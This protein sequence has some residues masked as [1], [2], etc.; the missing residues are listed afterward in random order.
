MLFLLGLS[1]DSVLTGAGSPVTIMA[2]PVQDLGIAEI[3][4]LHREQMKELARTTLLHPLPFPTSHGDWG[5]IFLT[6]IWALCSPLKAPWRIAGPVV[7]TQAQI[8]LPAPQ[9]PHCHHQVHSSPLPTDSVLGSSLLPTPSPNTAGRPWSQRM[10][11]LLNCCNCLCVWPSLFPSLAL[12][13]HLQHEKI[14][15]CFLPSL[16]GQYSYS[17]LRG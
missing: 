8:Q 4:D 10:S 2:F 3:T 5:I 9:S 7:T 1:A 6:D 14:R 11:D 12:F 15:L 13:I 16:S 17:K